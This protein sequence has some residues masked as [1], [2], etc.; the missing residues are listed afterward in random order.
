M[1]NKCSLYFCRYWH[2]SLNPKKLID[3]KFSHLSRNMTMQRTM[4]LY[5]LPE[6]NFEIVN[7]VR[8]SLSTKTLFVGPR[9]SHCISS[10]CTSYPPSSFIGIV[11]FLI[12]CH[13]DLHNIK[14]QISCLDSLLTHLWNK[15]CLGVPKFWSLCCK[16]PTFGKEGARMP[17]LENKYFGVAYSAVLN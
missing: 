6:V 8:E 4:K 5:R 7:N 14:W 2:R 1:D 3:V 12:W 16:K 9:T 17:F 15:W 11:L 10:C 13:I